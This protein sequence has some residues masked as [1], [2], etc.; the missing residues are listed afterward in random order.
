MST[1]N[2]LAAIAAVIL[3][4]A[5]AAPARASSD[6]QRPA[7][8]LLSTLEPSALADFVSEVL[9]RSP[10]LA[11]ARA[12]AAA[13]E[14]RAPQVRALPD[15]VASLTL[16]LLPPETRV[17]P[18]RLTVGVSQA[19]PWWS[20]LELRERDALYQ[21][22][23]ARA[24]VDAERLKLL[25]EARTLA[26]ELA[27]TVELA[28]IARQ[29]RDHLRRHEEAAQARYA[30][31]VGLQQAV[32]KVQAEI[33]RAEQR[34][35]EIEQRRRSLVSRLNALRERPADT[36]VPAVT[37]P[38][39]SASDLTLSE[40]DGA[41]FG[42]LLADLRAAARVQRPELVAL[43][44]QLQAAEARVELAQKRRL[45]DF[46]VG[47]GYT[48]VDRRDDAPGRANPPPDN[49]ED[50]LAITGGVRLPLWRESLAASLEEALQRQRVLE[51]AERQLHSDIERDLGDLLSRL[52]LLH[53]QCRL[54]DRVLLLQ[55]EEALHS[56]ETAYAT[57]KTDVLNLLD[58]EHVLFDVR[59]GRLRARADFVV[60]LAQLE[61]VT[62]VPLRGE[63]QTMENVQ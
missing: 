40:F 57:G 42:D 2:L 52:P 18:Q 23:A 15:P 50:I 48:V 17:G 49:G 33:T 58:A 59:R 3:L 45:P 46:T 32:I 60:A 7:D 61:G 43:Q 25:T 62:G 54:F 11:R 20:K 13:M 26:Y 9:E 5:A 4:A 19:L 44:A 21:A 12:E 36:A 34:L 6:S 16:F 30:A 53:E 22:A 27:F 47:L 41:S 51:F 63:L 31:G 24:Q 29:E 1:R 14:V 28:T 10:R 8:L 37:L 35:L 39:I 38:E 56:A 55:A